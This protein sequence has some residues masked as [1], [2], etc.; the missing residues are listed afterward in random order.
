M[1]PDLSRGGRQRLHGRRRLRLGRGGWLATAA[2]LL[3]ILAVGGWQAY[4]TW[5]TTRSD[6]VG[7][8]LVHRERA[9]VSAASHP[10]T[11]LAGTHHPTVVCTPGKAPRAGNAIGDLRGLL[12]IPA[13][14][15]VAPVEQGTGDPQLAVAVGHDPY[16]VWPGTKGTAVFLAHDV[17][18]FANI[19]QLKNGSAVR[20]VTPC[21][22]YDFVVDSQRVVVS[23]TAVFNSPGP[24]LL[25]GTCWPT[26]ALWYTP[27]RLLVTAHETKVQSN[28][29][30][31]K[32]ASTATSHLSVPAPPALVAQGLSLSDNSILIGTMT[33]AGHPAPAWVQSPAPMNVEASAL[34]AYFG[35]LHA[36]AQGHLDWW[37][38]LAPG[39]APPAP[40][41]SAQI[42]TYES[43]L[44]V[45]LR[46]NQS[47]P[48]SVEMSA[49]VQI[50]G[51]SHPG[52]YVMTVG[53]TIKGSTLTVS[54]WRL[55]PA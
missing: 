13:L 50:T 21:T 18:Y 2:G 25:M 30:S 10:T 48:T 41:V 7:S 42:T 19:N 14:G 33:I 40:L 47:S 39:L 11:S 15:L 43:R 8:A 44:T 6:H 46:A 32:T 16:S 12:E 3:L 9:L 45:T 24:T 4:A 1:D 54:S 29:A 28:V 5:W 23:G 55:A 27:D 49:S 53:E 20:F 36:L 22:T 31:S 35:S 38:D 37:K 26:N 51:G 52:S 17:S 34:E